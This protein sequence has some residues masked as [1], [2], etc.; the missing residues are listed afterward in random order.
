M[1][2]SA[3]LAIPLASSLLML[4][5]PSFLEW[6]QV[7]A[8]VCYDP[9]YPFGAIVV[10]IIIDNFSYHPLVHLQCADPLNVTG[11]KRLSQP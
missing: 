10:T 6:Q 11:Q 4:G 1:S 3:F 2:V 7:D 9:Q 8:A 5:L